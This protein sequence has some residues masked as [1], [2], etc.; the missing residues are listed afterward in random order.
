MSLTVK[1]A[2]VVC[3]ISICWFVSFA[4]GMWWGFLANMACAAVWG[5]MV[6]DSWLASHM[7]LDRDDR[8]T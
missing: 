7:P 8:S 4:A 6:R 1:L 3:W 2:A 5:R